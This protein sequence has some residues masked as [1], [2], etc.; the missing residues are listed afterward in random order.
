M[1]MIFVSLSISGW[2]QFFNV[3]FEFHPRLTIITGTNGA[4][5]STVLNL[6]T[7]T[8]GWHRNLLGTPKRKNGVQEFSTGIHKIEGIPVGGTMPVGA[9]TYS[10]GVEAQLLVMADAQQYNVGIQNQQPVVGT[11]IS[12][13]RPVPVFR[14]VSQ[15]NASTL[16]PDQA[17]NIYQGES[18]QRY[19]GN[20]GQGAIFRIKEALISL[21]LFGVHGTMSEGDEEALN[22][23]QGFVEVLRIM[24][25]ESLGF[26]NI[27][28]RVT[29]VILETTSGN[30]VIDAASGGVMSIIDIAWQI[31][32]FSKTTQ[33]ANAIKFTVVM[34]EPEN[35]LHPS[36]Q[37][38]L[39]A[40]LLEAFPAAQFIVATHSPFMVSSVKDSSVY[41]LR[42]TSLESNSLRQTDDEEQP[43]IKAVF[44]EKLDVVNRA[45]NASEI[46][47]D[48]LGVPVTVPL[49]VEEQLNSLVEEFRN[50]EISLESLAQL[51]DQMTSLGFGEMYPTALAR[52]VGVK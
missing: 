26:K 37:R 27:S 20:Q 13:H 21:A 16:H 49:W 36:M 30:F 52:V 44:S 5:K 15:I 43:V 23:F 41:A 50:R 14:Q 2:R 18:V 34:D 7:P 39:L 46:L 22:Y 45:G 9:M 40:N 31:Y 10:N 11:F 24:L 42:Y 17:Y 33:V 4:G 19:Q 3:S 6:L 38:N 8:F 1:S 47:R 32:T 28:I 48:V 35:H 51:R 29:D 12:S 25:P